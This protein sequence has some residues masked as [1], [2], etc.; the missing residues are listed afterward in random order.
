VH[1]LT[2]RTL[3]PLRSLLNFRSE[4]FAS[5]FSYGLTAVIKLASSLVLTRLL[6][7]TAYGIFGILLSVL[8][9]IELVSDVGT[10][11]LL[12][13]HPRG[14]ERAFVHTL[15]TIRLIRSVINCAILFLAAPL[16]AA[17]Y[18][19]AAL[20]NALRLLSVWFLLTGLESLSFGLCIRHQRARVSNYT[21][22]A[23]NTAMT[24]FVIGMAFVLKNHYAL[25]LGALLQR[26]LIAAA[27]HFYYRDIGI[28]FA[29]DREAMRAQF[30]FARFVVPSSILTVVLSQYDK[31]V[32]A[33]LF[34]M[35]VV[36]LYTI[37]GNMLAPLSGIIVHNA[38]F[39]LYGRCSHYFRSGNAEL[40]AKRYYSEN[41]KL[42]LVGVLPAAM[43]AGS[44]PLIVSILYDPRYAAAGHILTFL[45]FGVML[46]AFQNASENLLVASGSTHAVLGGNIARLCSSLPAAFLGYY[47]GGLEGFL[48]FTM[49]ANLIPLLYYWW[50]Q[51][52]KRLLDL[53][54]ELAYL[55]LGVAAFLV[56][57]AVGH[58]LLA[59]I[60]S[61]W[62]H[63]GI[64]RH[65]G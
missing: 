65:A 12:I 11:G 2:A 51:R 58:L 28:G 35:S 10:T 37:A 32:L 8:F 31:I 14:D 64:R 56:S 45:A 39:V 26:L 1:S 24:L 25:I 7:P 54:K 34:A 3:R 63:L 20:T 6:D 59:I 13:R 44:A 18:H 49:C 50:E 22:M 42:F 40:A 36:G 62:L 61:Q 48:W 47:L 60:P 27:S 16:V 17:L 57:F 52:R 43:V 4:L 29:F 41:V 38:R 9:V 33:R 23:S 21:E 5:T 15:W 53:R 19:T 55:G 46:G 30:G